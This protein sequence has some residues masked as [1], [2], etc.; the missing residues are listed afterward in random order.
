MDRPRHGHFAGWRCCNIVVLP[1]PLPVLHASACR[2][3]FASFSSSC[4]S[5]VPYHL[6]VF[7]ASRTLLLEPIVLV[8]CCVE[9]G[10]GLLRNYLARWYD[11][12]GVSV[13]STA[14]GVP[15]NKDQHLVLLALRSHCALAK[16]SED[17]ASTWTRRRSSSHTWRSLLHATDQ[18]LWAEIICAQSRLP[19]HFAGT[20]RKHPP[21]RE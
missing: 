5:M 14:F 4:V 21:R 6:L 11:V 16:P 9:Y 12:S 10:E 1:A 2:L 8:D 18:E 19:T 7:V 17:M 13:N 3:H 20:A 15:H